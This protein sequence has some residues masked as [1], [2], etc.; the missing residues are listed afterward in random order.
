MEAAWPKVVAT[1]VPPV[2]PTSA[3]TTTEIVIEAVAL[4]VSVATT[5]TE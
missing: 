1:F 4:F 5:F 2:I 3:F